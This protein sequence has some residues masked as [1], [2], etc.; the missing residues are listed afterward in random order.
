[1]AHR[2]LFLGNKQK[3]YG[4]KQRNNRE[5]FDAIR[6]VFRTGSPWCDIP[7]EPACWQ[8]VYKRFAQWNESDMQ[9][10]VSE[11]M[12]FEPDMQD[13]SIGAFTSKLIDPA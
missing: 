6:W 2:E 3:Q 11:A 8:T 4:R 7:Q 9:K 10:K 5:I 1:M 13:I 12:R